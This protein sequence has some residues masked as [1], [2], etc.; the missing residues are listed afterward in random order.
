MSIVLPNLLQL[1]G[2]FV[3]VA[4]QF[5]DP[6]DEV[7][8]RG[9]V[10]LLTEAALKSCFQPVAFFAEGPYLDVGEFQV[11]TQTH[12]A[13]GASGLPVTG[14]TAR[15]LGTGLVDVLARSVGVAQP[16]RDPRRAGDAA[17]VT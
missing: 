11:G 3:F 10:E 12:C 7:L 5:I 2:Q 16:V 14:G 15:L 4:G 17:K 1:V 13:R 6:G 9:L 8:R